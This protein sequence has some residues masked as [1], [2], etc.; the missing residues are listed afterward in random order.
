MKRRS[1]WDRSAFAVAALGASACLTDLD[2]YELRSSNGGAGGSAGTAPGGAQGSGAASGGTIGGNGGAMGGGK[3]GAVSAGGT[4]TGGVTGTGGITDSGGTANTGGVTSTGGFAN[5]GGV[6][7]TGGGTGTGGV[8]GTPPSCQGLATT[9]GP[10][11]DEDCCTSLLVPGGTFYRSYDGVTSGFTS[12]AYPATVSDFRLDK[13]EITVGRW[14]KFAAA[15]STI[16]IAPG[17]G[18]NPNDPNDPGW[19]SIWNVN[20]SPSVAQS[21]D[22]TWTDSPGANEDKPVSCLNWYAAFSFCIWDG[23]RLPT[24]AEWNYAA[25]GGS[26]QR[27][28]PWGSAT[29]DCTYLNFLL[30]SGACV[31][32][33]ND[34][35][36]ESPKGDGKW[37]QA[38]LS[39][40]VGEWTVDGY[41]DPYA[42]VPCTNCSEVSTLPG[43]SRVMRGLGWSAY[44][45]L[46]VPVSHRYELS[47][48]TYSAE[49]GARCA[50]SP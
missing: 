30:P 43:G 14:R 32:A 45:A 11:H 39:G 7:N 5:A 25:A 33:P 20:M 12:K 31:G 48:G 47:M 41:V 1:R 23:G 37:G 16:A 38:D 2:G 6:A 18:K 35:G 10:S 3:G 49:I 8:T 21:S 50:R 19:Q 42:I 29:P 24:E 28:F 13:Y 27:E 9:C 34:V 44:G 40:N 26:E 15:F 22:C 36:S 17:S 46:A 4:N